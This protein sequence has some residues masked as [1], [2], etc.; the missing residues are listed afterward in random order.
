MSKGRNLTKRKWGD[1][2]NIKYIKKPKVKRF[3]R[4]KKVLKNFE[5]NHLNMKG[6]VYN[7]LWFNM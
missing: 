4:N 7:Y 5:G 6:A 1:I 3:P 2:R